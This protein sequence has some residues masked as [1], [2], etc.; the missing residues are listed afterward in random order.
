LCAQPPATLDAFKQWHE[1]CQAVDETLGLS[2]NSAAV[3]GPSLSALLPIL[4]AWF[5]SLLGR[6]K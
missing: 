5:V 6:K 3:L 1:G 2:V 4:S